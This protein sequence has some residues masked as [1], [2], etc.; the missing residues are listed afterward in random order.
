MAD[1]CA[2]VGTRGGQCRRNAEGLLDFCS[3]HNQMVRE[4]HI[5]RC[6]KCNDADMIW[7]EEEGYAAADAC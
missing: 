3:R 4:G 2:Q 6:W 7:H 5:L 1:R